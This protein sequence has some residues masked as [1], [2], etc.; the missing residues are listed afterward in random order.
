MQLTK[1][2]E[3]G[4]VVASLN[5][6]ERGPVI[7][8]LLEGLA[9]SGRIDDSAVDPLHNAVMKRERKG[10][11]GFGHGVAVPHAK[12]DKVSQ[13]CIA[14]GLST[15]GVEFNALDRQPVYAFFLLLS[16]QGE[17]E[18]HLDAMETVFGRLSDEGFRR[19]LRQSDN[20][21]DVMTLISESDTSSSG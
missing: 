2:V 8:E 15:D 7:R 9:A 16:P 11:T 5:A 4:A 12:T 14:V 1:L 13:I 6:S 19:F 10:S 18:L 17:P 3:D 20:I 21:E